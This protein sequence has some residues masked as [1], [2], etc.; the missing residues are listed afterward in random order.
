MA[1]IKCPEC[2]KEISNKAQTCPN[3]GYPIQNNGQVR[4]KIPNNVVDGFAGLLSSR[5]CFITE[6]STNKTLWSGKHGENAS[7]TINKPTNVTVNLGSWGNP[8]SGTVE[9]NKKYTLIQD[10][11]VH[12]LAT[13]RLSEV[14]IIDSE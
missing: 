6:D 12:L 2:G 1:L 8:V 7:F 10:M 4:I 3:C 14:D 13:Y 11:G 5:K 9:P